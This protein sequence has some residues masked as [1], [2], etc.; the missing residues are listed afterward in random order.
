MRHKYAILALVVFILLMGA[1]FYVRAE[2]EKYHVHGGQDT[3]L[4]V[5]ET[6]A[7]EDFP[8]QDSRLWVYGNANEDDVIDSAD[9]EYLEGVIDGANPETRLCDANLDG[10]VDWNDVL[11]LQRILDDGEVDVYYIDSYYRNASVSWPV[12]S[13]AIGYCSGAYA[14]DLIGVCDKVTMVDTTIESYWYVMNSNFEKAES[15]GTTENPIYEKMIRNGIDVYV[16]GYCDASADQQS[17]TKLNPVGIDVMFLSTADNSGVDYP[18]EHIDRTLVM[19]AFLLQGDTE[20]TY[21]YL[22]WHDDVLSRLME[23][24]S[25]LTESQKESFM[26]AR[27]SLGG[28]SSSGTISITGHNNTNN[29]HAE[30]VGVNAVGQHSPD[31]TKNYQ[32]VTQEKLLAIIR[33]NQSHGRLF[34]MDNEHDGMRGQYSLKD[35]VEADAMMLG[36]SSV[37]ITYMGMARE[38]G[39][40]PLYVVEL[41]F[42]VCVMYPDLAEQAGIDYEELFHY[43]FETF[44]SED[45]SEHVSDIEKFF[46]LRERGSRN[47]PSG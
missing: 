38:A 32:D 30:W 6:L 14:A 25:S 18:N 47:H 16:V 36:S 13:I 22:D 26:M 2:N 1:L 11:Y 34:Y 37:N 46:Y 3:G 9:L 45:Y 44:S 10:R 23:V 41:A 40:S 8:D 20:K 19:M 24:T 35:C 33:E 31:L 12:N 21:E 5:G 42:Y 27:T 7:E 28:S 39:N 17:P 15:Y 4:L 29:I 43:Y